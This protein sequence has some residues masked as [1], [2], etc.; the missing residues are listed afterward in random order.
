[1]NEF[2][3]SQ[4]PL[5]K[6]ENF[7]VKEK[8][9][10]VN[11]SAA[12]E[13]PEDL[14]LDVEDS[15][16]ADVSDGISSDESV[17]EWLE[18]YVSSTQAHLQNL[19]ALIKYTKTKD[20]SIYKLSTELQKY[21]EDYCA[22]LFK[23]VGMAII[24]FREDC[25]KSMTDI[26]KYQYDAEKVN[27]YLA[28][29][30]DDY[31]EML[32]NVGIEE[33]DNGWLFNGSVINQHEAENEP[34]LIDPFDELPIANETFDDVIPDVRSASDLLA[35]LNTVE[36]EVKEILSRNETLDRCLGAYIDYSFN[37]EKNLVK[38]Y[39][40]PSVRM[41]VSIGEKLRITVDEMRNTVTDEDCG[42]KYKQCLEDVVNALEDAL[43]S[44]GIVIDADVRDEFDPK[45]DRLLKTVMTDNAELDRKI[46]FVHTECYVMNE[47][48]IYPS[49][50]DVY[51][52]AHKAEEKQNKGE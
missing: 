13:P 12:L 10:S 22:K 43:L 15:F 48:V 33:N 2:D 25:R 39:V 26:D 30:V 17:P 38:I 41:L 42:K 44:G 21:R 32:S 29:L 8:E 3:E 45:K 1:M 16:D 47:K 20:E 5:D 40:L 19:R 18:E 34:A 31:F 46:A 4:S 52:F 28:F 50:V 37:I 23:P 36:N 11:A 6:D 35:Y 9:E 27:K 51:K 14:I 7:I 49:K 24:S